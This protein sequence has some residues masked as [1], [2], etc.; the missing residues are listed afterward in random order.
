MTPVEKLEW[1]AGVASDPEVT[2]AAVRVGAFLVNSLNRKT[3]QCNPK[4]ATI[5]SGTGRSEATVKRALR[6]LIGSGWVEVLTTGNGVGNTSQYGFGKGVKKDPVKGVKSKPLRKP[7]GVKSVPKRGSNLSGKGVKSALPLIYPLISETVKETVKETG[8]PVDRPDPVPP[9]TRKKATPR[10]PAP[11]AATWAA[12]AAAYQTRYGIEP[13]RNAAVN[14]QISAFLKRIGA[15]DSPGVAAHYVASNNGFYVR[16]GHSTGAMLRDAEKLWTEW[17]TGRRI[18]QA[19]AAQI[20]RS[21]SNYDAGAEAKAIM[22]KRN[23]G[24]ADGH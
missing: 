15:E 7:K 14:S 12:Y 23:G 13:K 10:P 11:T 8:L 20:D 16:S 1:I 17:A 2:D 9:Q 5:M 3:G 18:T 21:Q 24:G 22:A 4:R 6:N 19:Q